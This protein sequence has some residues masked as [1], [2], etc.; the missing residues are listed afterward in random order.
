MIRDPRTPEQFHRR[1]QK[2][3][4]GH[5]PLETCYSCQRAQAQCKSKRQRFEDPI[6]ASQAAQRQ[7][8]ENDWNRPVLPY[9]CTWCTLWHVATVKGRD[10]KRR[11]ARQERRAKRVAVQQ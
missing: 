8:A 2:R 7:N 3:H 6:T 9:R 4:G 11:V 1:H 10:Q 5:E